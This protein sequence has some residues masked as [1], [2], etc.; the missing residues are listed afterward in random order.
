MGEPE[1]D[2][3]D[4]RECQRGGTGDQMGPAD[5]VVV[6]VPPNDDAASHGVGVCV[7]PSSQSATE[8]DPPWRDRRICPSSAATL[9]ATAVQVW[10]GSGHRPGMGQA[11][12]D[13]RVDAVGVGRA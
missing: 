12:R 10:Q 5:A 3:L 1:G 7:N 9:R 4:L 2:Q 11:A 6:G 8:L 13:N